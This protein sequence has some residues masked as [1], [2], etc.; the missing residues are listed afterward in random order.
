[1]DGRKEEQEERE[2]RRV[3]GRGDEMNPLKGLWM[4][5][6]DVAALF[7]KGISPSSWGQNKE[8]QHSSDGVITDRV[9]HHE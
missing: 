4:K 1:M 9:L 5:K 7:I 2:R 3:E 8:I 6:E